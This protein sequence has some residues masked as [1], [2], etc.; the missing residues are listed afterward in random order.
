VGVSFFIYNTFLSPFPFIFYLTPN[1]PAGQEGLKYRPILFYH[2]L[3]LKEKGSGD[4][5]KIKKKGSG[6]EV[7]IKEKGSGDEVKIWGIGKLS[8]IEWFK[9]IL[10]FSLLLSQIIFNWKEELF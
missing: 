4:E 9:I 3:L 7:K 1:S 6:D 10:L 2:P 8:V 5:V